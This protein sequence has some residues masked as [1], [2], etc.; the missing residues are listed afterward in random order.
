MKKILVLG[1][2]G[3][4]GR[5]LCEELAKNGFA[6]TVPT[7]RVYHARCVQHLQHLNIVET[8][9]QDES[10]LAALLAGHDAVINLVGILH[11]S[12]QAFNEVHVELARKLAAA[13]QTA[14]VRRVIHVSCL[15]QSE[16]APSRYLRS[17]TEG[18]ALLRAAPLAL[19][20]IRPSVVFG[21]DDRFMNTLGHWSTL[22]PVLPVPAPDAR[23]QPVWVRDL[24]VAIVRCV[25]DDASIG[26]TYEAVGPEALSMRE[27]AELACQ[28][29]H[30][31]GG[32]PTPVVRLPMA[33]AYFEAWLMEIMPGEPLMS[34]DNLETAR[35]P[36]VASG[37]L[38]TLAALGVD[39]QS[40]RGIA[41]AYMGQDSRAARLDRFRQYANR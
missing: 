12:E 39:A 40:M 34:R 32:E 33:L 38:P 28:W 41:P 19:T 25:Q 14:R 23:L 13:C 21:A 37:E 29:S 8:D 31:G 18:E 26:K 2:T 27:I 9:I 4:I 15:G 30:M 10:R 7:R 3:F 36:S 6:M 5:N 35:V 16:D 20:V 24:A 22:L 11:G 17:K 1:G